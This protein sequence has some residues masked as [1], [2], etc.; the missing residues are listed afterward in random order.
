V[1][2]DFLG[3][4]FLSPIDLSS[5]NSLIATSWKNITSTLQAYIAGKNQNDHFGA[6][7]DITNITF[8]LGMFSLNGAA[9]GK[10]QFYY[11]SPQIANSPNGTHKVDENSIY[12]I[13]N[14][15][16]V[17]T[18]LASLLGLKDSD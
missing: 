3:A 16:K 17:F 7:A 13:A 12:C 4:S 9:A 15:T 1:P 8:S 11:T 6:A 5:S 18:I 10:L 2:A 14:L